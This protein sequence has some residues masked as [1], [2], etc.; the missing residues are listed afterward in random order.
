MCEE[1]RSGHTQI[2][3]IGRTKR[4]F[5]LLTTTLYVIELDLTQINAHLAPP[6]KV[7]VNRDAIHSRTRASTYSCRHAPFF[8]LHLSRSFLVCY[9][10]LLFCLCLILALFGSFS[11]H[12][13]GFALTIN[14]SF[15]TMLAMHYDHYSLIQCISWLRVRITSL[16][17]VVLCNSNSVPASHLWPYYCWQ[18]FIAAL[19]L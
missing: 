18:C 13:F 16:V 4:R 17:Q 1:I 6:Y 11:P 3:A 14:R 5:L 10:P 12:M 15:S 7:V 8:R 2:L 9:S 19:C